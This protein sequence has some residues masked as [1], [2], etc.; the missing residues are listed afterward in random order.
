MLYSTNIRLGGT[1]VNI[2]VLTMVGII[3]TYATKIHPVKFP[4]SHPRPYSWDLSGPQAQA[5]SSPSFG[6]SHKGPSALCGRTQAQCHFCLA[7]DIFGK[8]EGLCGHPQYCH[9]SPLESSDL[10]EVEVE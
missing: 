9:G 7:P 1:V 10:G 4:L 5:P 8:A 2:I 6:L 3:I